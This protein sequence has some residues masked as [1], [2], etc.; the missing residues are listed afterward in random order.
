MNRKSVH[1]N[2]MESVH[3][4]LRIIAFKNNLSMQEIISNLVV[5]LVDKDEY[6]IEM[7]Q[8]IKEEKKNKQIRKLTNVESGDIFDHI[9]ESSPIKKN[10]N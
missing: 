4:E 1:I 3:S 9:N 6:M 5:K 8:K 7:L 2:L 10:T